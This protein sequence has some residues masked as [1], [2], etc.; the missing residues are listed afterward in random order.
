MKEIGRRSLGILALAI[1]ALALVG[2]YLVTKVSPPEVGVSS[3]PATRGPILIEEDA[4][5]T[6][7]GAGKGC[8]CARAGSGTERDPYVISNWVIN[9]SGSAGISLLGTS[10]YFTIK[11]VQ[12]QGDGLSTGINLDQVENGRI[13]ESLITNNFIGAYVYQSSNLQFI[14]NTIEKN[15]YGIQL[16]DS[17]SNR[18]SSNHFNQIGEVAIFVRGSENSVT[19]NAV[20]SAFGGINIDGTGGG[21]NDNLVDQNSVSNTTTYGIGVWRAAR[22]VVRSNL[23]TH[24]Q[25]VGITLAEG[26]SNNTVEQNEVIE[27]KG[28]GIVLAQGTLY[29]SVRGNTAKRNGDGVS[30]FDLADTGSANTWENNSYDTKTPETLD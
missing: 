8:E 10:S 9:A 13:E 14:N 5:F 16:E 12:V 19:G 4:D 11:R 1:L 20:R 25:G 29:N 21:A 3:T 18:V 22:T 23:V 28:G 17:Y 30:S 24:N 2:S 15:T 27:N 26:S 6:R 7:V